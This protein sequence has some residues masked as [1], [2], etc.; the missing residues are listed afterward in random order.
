MKKH[1]LAVAVVGACV[2][3]LATASFAQTTSGGGAGQGSAG[4][5]TSGTTPGNPSNS[6]TTAGAAGATT[7][8]PG[9]SGSAG[10]GSSIAKKGQDTAE[11]R[12]PHN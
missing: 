6:A 12:V 8:T 1:L 7:G 2:A 11:D 4:G 9:A 10:M 5:A 3:G